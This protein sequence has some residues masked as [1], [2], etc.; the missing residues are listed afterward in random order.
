VLCGFVFRL[1]LGS[2]FSQVFHHGVGIDLPRWADLVLVLEFIFEFV[3]IL[4]FSEQA[5]KNA[6]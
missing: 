4:A 3:F 5:A 2:Q 1:R 6:A